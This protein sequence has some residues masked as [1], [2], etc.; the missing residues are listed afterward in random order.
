MDIPFLTR[1]K[2][3]RAQRATIRYTTLSAELKEPLPVT[4][5]ISDLLHEIPADMFDRVSVMD[6]MSHHMELPARSVIHAIDQVNSALGIAHAASLGSTKEKSYISIVP[7]REYA[8]LEQF[9]RDRND[10]YVAV[11]ESF[12]QLHERLTLLTATILGDDATESALSVYQLRAL[13]PLLDCYR[14]WLLTLH[15]LRAVLDLS[16]I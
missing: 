1:F 13:Y 5:L 15:R 7:E 11:G 4:R 3:W 6:L 10:A 2:L 9:F 14:T 8:T 12:L 16:S